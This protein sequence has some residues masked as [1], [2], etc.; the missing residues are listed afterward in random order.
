[1]NIQTLKTTKKINELIEEYLRKK[2]TLPA[3]Q[4]TLEAFCSNFENDIPKEL[5]D[6]VRNFIE[7]LERIQHMYNKSE[8]FDAVS[9]EI[10]KFNE[11]LLKYHA[12]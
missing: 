2:V 3:M 1:M 10:K 6:N 7:D 5:Q 8:Q 9:N 11:M 12:H 4:S